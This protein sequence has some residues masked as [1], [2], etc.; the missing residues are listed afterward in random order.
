M[1]TVL[2][3]L[4]CVSLFSNSTP[5]LNNANQ[6]PI[7]VKSQTLLE[8]ALNRQGA[9][10]VGDFY[11]P[12]YSPSLQNKVQ[13]LQFALPVKNQYKLNEC[14]LYAYVHFVELVMRNTKKNSDAKSISAEYLFARKMYEIIDRR[15]QG[16]RTD[17]YFEGGHFYDALYLTEKYG[18]VPEEVWHPLKTIFQFDYN[19][20]NLFEGDIARGQLS[21]FDL[22]IK[23]LDK[24][25]AKGNLSENDLQTH[26]NKLRSKYLTP[27][28]NMFGALPE[29]FVVNGKTYSPIEYAD[30]FDSSS[31]TKFFIHFPKDNLDQNLM[32]ESKAR[33][34]H[35][36]K[37]QSEVT[38]SVEGL[39]FLI[40]F[41]STQVDNNNPTFLNLHWGRGRHG[42]VIVGYERSH[43]NNQIIRFKVLNS[44]GADWSDKGY[45]WY[46]PE[47]I[48]KNLINSVSV[49]PA[50]QK[51]PPKKSGESAAD[52]FNF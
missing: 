5:S 16:Y 11:E 25:R 49:E 12:A 38:H 28:D 33:F 6:E 26:I 4:I 43:I 32:N 14:Y 40:Q 8:T 27:L 36:L 29:R 51:H 24:L 48:Y 39:N 3:P 18:L 20:L 37:D 44:W 35:H 47:D 22:D 15:I 2:G 34:A 45:A 7:F 50:S 13:K 23:T 42:L 41:W 9:R 19:F 1:K 21:A 10:A 17:L 31:Y 52:F 46:T 30:A